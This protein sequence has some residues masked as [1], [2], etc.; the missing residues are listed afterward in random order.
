MTH[1]RAW[2][3]S[4][5]NSFAGKPIYLVYEKN[6]ELAACFPGLIVNVGMLRLFGSPL[7]GWQTVSMGPVFDPKR[8]STEEIVSPLAPYLESQY[9]VHHIEL[10]TSDFDDHSME[11]H[12]FRGKPEYTFK[13]P[14]YPDDKQKSLKAMKQSARRNIRRAGELA[15]DIKTVDDDRFVNEVYDQITEVFI[16]GGNSVPFQKKRVEEFFVNM[17]LAGKLLALGVYLPD[18]KICIATSLFTIT[19]NE[20]VL[21]MWTHRTEYRWYRATEAMTWT[22]MQTAMERGCDTMDLMG[23]GDF[24]A[25][26]GATISGDKIRW[27]RSRYCW[28]TVAR[29]LAE[30]A[31]R[32]QQSVR[33]K[34]IRR[35][36]L[37][38]GE[39]ARR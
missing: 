2:L 33:G 12:G 3:R 25:K 19:N 23:R 1:S 17:R 39:T 8:I 6:G 13:A 34:Y 22:A 24:K 32:L 37:P 31:Y 21:W 29:D 11:G 4:L 27:V 35:H 28:L 38:R 15:L 14:L 26:F 18:S 5:A 16:R 10:M 30:K 7:P 20:L 36:Q 9:G